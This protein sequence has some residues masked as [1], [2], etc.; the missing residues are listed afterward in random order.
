MI[1]RAVFAFDKREYDFRSGDSSFVAL[2][3]YQP[4]QVPSQ[5]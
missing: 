1:K 3:A 4:D 5:G 2:R